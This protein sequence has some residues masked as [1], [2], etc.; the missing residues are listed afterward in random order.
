MLGRRFGPV[1]R[2]FKEAMPL[3][4]CNWQSIFFD[5]YYRKLFHPSRSQV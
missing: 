5:E 3:L 4:E 1:I 2:Q